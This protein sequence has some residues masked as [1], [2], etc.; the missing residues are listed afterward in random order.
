MQ[1]VK[2]TQAGINRS[3]VDFLTIEQIKLVLLVDHHKNISRVGTLLKVERTTVSTRLSD[4]ERKLGTDLF[5]RN[6]NGISR[7]ESGSSFIRYASRI[8]E[9]AGDLQAEFDGHVGSRGGVARV[10]AAASAL[11]FLL[12]A[13]KA[14]SSTR[15]QA[16]IKLSVTNHQQMIEKL[17]QGIVDL[18]VMDRDASHPELMAEKFADNP[19]S[20]LVLP[21]HPFSRQA[22]VSLR[23][24]ERFP[25]LVREPGAESRMLLDRFFAR[26]NVPVVP[27]ME[28]DSAEALKQALFA[29]VRENSLAFLSEHLVASELKRNEFVRVNIDGLPLH[30]EWCCVYRKDEK[31]IGASGDLCQILVQGGE[32]LIADA[33]RGSFVK[34]SVFKK[35]KRQL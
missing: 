8:I 3:G 7:T 10:A 23:Q 29:R 11:P 16:L 18:C 24:I 19:H 9:L 14:L 22:V 20:F 27:T 12:H 13:I 4:I 1:K 28:F 35:P 5:I 31:P 30:T 17:A 6:K 25:L 21:N 34:T 2:D 15:P 33:L 26:H 32:S